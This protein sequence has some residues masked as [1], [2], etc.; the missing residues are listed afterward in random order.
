VFGPLKYH[1]ER[2][3]C[4]NNLE[5]QMAFHDWLH[6]VQID[7]YRDGILTRAMFRINE[8]VCW[9]TMLKILFTGM[10]KLFKVLLIS[11]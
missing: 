4:S 6:M 10:H 1:C 2:F 3:R 11:R 7:F 5:V 9:W 8:S